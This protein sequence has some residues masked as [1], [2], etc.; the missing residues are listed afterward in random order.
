[1]S[2]LGLYNIK[3]IYRYLMF[4]KHL[5]KDTLKLWNY[6]HT[7]IIQICFPLAPTTNAG[8]SSLQSPL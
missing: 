6:T 5:H 3:N 2:L 4:L 1:M 7:Q 8:L